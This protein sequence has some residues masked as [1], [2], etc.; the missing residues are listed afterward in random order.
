MARTF[1]VTFTRV[2]VAW[3]T[4]EV[5]EGFDPMTDSYEGVARE[6]LYRHKDDL[7]FDHDDADTD[8]EI[9]DAPAQESAG[10]PPVPATVTLQR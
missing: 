2:G 4:I 1:D 6:W 8:I 5:P 10:A 7:I 3:A 9:W